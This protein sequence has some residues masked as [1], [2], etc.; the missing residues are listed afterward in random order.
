[1][2]SSLYPKE[3]RSGNGI[4]VAA[5]PAA[6]QECHLKTVKAA[7]PSWTVAFAPEKTR[8]KWP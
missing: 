3:A 1:L 4:D 7:P 2:T 5:D 6:A 8:V